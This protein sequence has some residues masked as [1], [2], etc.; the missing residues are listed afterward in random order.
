M[1]NNALFNVK[2]GIAPEK[3]RPKRRIV[4]KE[5]GTAIKALSPFVYVYCREL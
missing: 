2:E 1:I 5:K 3:E 4:E